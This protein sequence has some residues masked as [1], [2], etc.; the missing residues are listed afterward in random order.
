[1]EVG[2]CRTLLYGFKIPKNYQMD[3]MTI[4]PSFC[5]ALD[6]F[7]TNPQYR[8]HVEDADED[9]DENKGTLIIG[10]MQKDRRK[11]RKQG[12]ELLTIGF[13]VYAVSPV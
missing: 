6:T 4:C 2:L 9:D 11:L 3:L 13:M 10:L 7:W 8:V 1:M 5:I 12:A